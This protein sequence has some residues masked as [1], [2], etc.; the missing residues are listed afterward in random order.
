MPGNGWCTHPKRQL[1]SGV[2]LLVRG[3]ELACRNSWGGDLFQSRLDDEV[4][5]VAA[6]DLPGNDRDDEVTSVT[7]PSTRSEPAEDRVVRDR[8]APQRTPPDDANDAAH[9]DQ[10]ERARI[11][12]RGSRDAVAQARQRFSSRHQPA[13]K[14]A[15]VAD[16]DMAAA[17]SGDRVVTRQERFSDRE[18]AAGLPHV[19]T[20]PV[21]R[22]EVQ[23][24][25][26]A[27]PDRF[28]TVPAIDPDF[29]MPGQRNRTEP[30]A[31]AVAEPE[32]APDPIADDEQV[33][34]YEHVL[35][36]ARRIRASKQERIRPIRHAD[37]LL[38]RDDAAPVDA[39]DVH[40]PAAYRRADD[41][42]DDLED[43]NA[44]HVEAHAAYDDDPGWNDAGVE[45]LETWDGDRDDTEDAWERSADDDLETE[46][47]A[48]EDIPDDE[49]EDGL[50]ASWDHEDDIWEDEDDS[51]YQPEP[52]RSG[53]L[54][55][56]RL[57]RHSPESTY[58]DAT[59][60]RHAGSSHG[61]RDDEPIEDDRAWAHH[62]PEPAP[63][64]D[65]P[66]DNDLPPW[67]EPMRA[68]AYAEELP[69]PAPVPPPVPASERAGESWN[70]ASMPVRPLAPARSRK[71]LDAELPDLDDALFEDRED[72]VLRAERS[73]G[74]RAES[75]TSDP[76]SARDSFFRASRYPRPEAA[77][78][79]R[80]G[81]EP[82]VLDSTSALPDLDGDRLDL[83]DVVARGAEMVD[84]RIEVAPDVP[85]QC[86]TCRSFRSADGGTRGWCTNEWA[87][88]H[89]RM[90]N[91][92]DLA[93]VSAIGCWWLPAD[94]LR[95]DLDDDADGAR[96]PRMD[97]LIASKNPAKRRV[98]GE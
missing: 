95:L 10:E 58:D 70:A 89:R 96:T 57:G 92:D 85:R 15:V 72:R 1:A 52:R 9:R 41:W 6:A 45:T 80:D 27:S 64:W 86:R 94:H 83:R 40:E 19:R 21:P 7:I 18:F 22:E 24:R 78:P 60:T 51:Y 17:G 26:V 42:R 5:P 79:F 56:F 8:P 63:S 38:N 88:T 55:R 29:D 73:T 25:R 68:H 30:Q 36:R 61:Y 84:R 67:Q 28:D 77:S 3:G 62:D 93:C 75:A 49:R 82:A 14:D 81:P 32:P 50:A 98:A 35:Q 23:Q 12:A 13:A 31:A 59:I 76:I 97:E 69:A 48:E 54:S 43:A 33:T 91:D 46:A 53:W 20:G 16:D 47:W 71:P 37:I 65:D 87:F 74:M 2:K 90:V 39:P 11:M 66:F 34:A 4:T 44:A